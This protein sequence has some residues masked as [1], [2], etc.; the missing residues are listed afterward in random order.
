MHTR[1]G[2]C[3]RHTG[4]ALSPFPGRAV[5]PVAEE[6]GP[7]K[8]PRGLRPLCPQTEPAPGTTPTARAG[9]GP[10]GHSQSQHRAPQPQPEPA[11][12]PAA[13]ARAGTGPRAVP[14]TPP[15]TRESHRHRHAWHC[16][17]INASIRIIKGRIFGGKIQHK[18]HASLNMEIQNFISNL[19]DLN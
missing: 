1:V 5:A 9:T 13:R 4:R 18:E 15:G 3:G 19:L 10:R 16:S 2:R 17:P 11:P 14:A 7:E 12:G 8:T 6:P